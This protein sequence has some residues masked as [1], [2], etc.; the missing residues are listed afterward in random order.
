MGAASF[1]LDNGA[2][3][4]DVWETAARGYQRRVIMQRKATWTLAVL[5]VAVLGMGSWAVEAAPAKPV[6]AAK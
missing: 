4:L 1:D 3:K 5:S 2:V 6:E